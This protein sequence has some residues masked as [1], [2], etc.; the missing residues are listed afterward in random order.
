MCCFLL[1]EGGY[2]GFY[3][4]LTPTLI[5][6]APYAGTRFLLLL[7]F[8]SNRAFFYYYCVFILMGFWLLLLFSPM[9][10]GFSFFTFGTLKSLGLAH[11]PELLGRPSSDNPDVLVLKPQV[12]LLC[13]GIAGAIAQTISWASSYSHTSTKC[14]HGNKGKSNERK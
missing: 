9:H 6:M 13:G 5:G 2:S 11:A 10:K 4:G 3:R 8:H 14:C 7:C 1:K 12:N